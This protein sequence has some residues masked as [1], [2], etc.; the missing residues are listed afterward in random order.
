MKKASTLQ[1]LEV[2]IE[3]A[4]GSTSVAAAIGVA[5]SLPSMWKRRGQIPVANCTAIERATA[6][7]VTRRDLRPDDWH[8]HWP[9]LV[10]Q[11]ST[12]EVSHD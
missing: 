5:S 3:I 11:T 4:G 6:G 1:A 2:A 9:E 8:L 7:R 10:V 12:Q